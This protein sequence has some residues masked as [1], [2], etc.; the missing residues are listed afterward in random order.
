[1]KMAVDRVRS[2]RRTASTVSAKVSAVGR[3]LSDPRRVDILGLLRQGPATTTEISSTLHLR[4]SET[5]VQLA[6]LR[7]GGWVRVTARG[8]HRLYSADTDFISRTIDLVLDIHRGVHLR[9]MGPQ[10]TY[11]LAPQPRSVIREARSC[12]DHLAG[13]AGVWLADRLEQLGWV[14]R[15][16]G[17]FLL[18]LVGEKGLAEHG[19]DLAVLHETRRK[20][21]PACLDWTEHRWHIGGALGSEILRSLTRSGLLRRG[22]LR[23][24]RLIRPL[25]SWFLPAT[26]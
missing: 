6:K 15:G 1:M 24:I 23:R 16:A 14:V 21:A 17:G 26:E 25:D 12:Y 10:E 11:L 4:V 8:R 2:R 18:T 22:K 3:I 20:F 9:W 7:M 5:S 19:I 13:K